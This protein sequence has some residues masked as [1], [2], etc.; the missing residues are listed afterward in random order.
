MSGRQEY[1]QVL[2]SLHCSD[3]NYVETDCA[4][5]DIRG[6]Y[7][8]TRDHWNCRSIAGVDGATNC[9]RTFQSFSMSD[10]D[11][12]GEA[13]SVERLNQDLSRSFQ[14]CHR[15]LFDYRSQL[16]ANSNQPELLDGMERSSSA[17]LDQ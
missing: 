17:K 16:A 9:A 11:E 5:A 2:F 6:E 1:W 10:K 4:F 14:R 12:S 7:C 3:E 13:A 15:L 8:V